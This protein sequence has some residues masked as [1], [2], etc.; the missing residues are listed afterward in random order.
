[1]K[2]ILCGAIT[3]LLVVVFALGVGLA[4]QRGYNEGWNG[5]IEENNLYERY[6]ED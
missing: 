6:K 3:V 1:M 2:K 4:Y 5:C